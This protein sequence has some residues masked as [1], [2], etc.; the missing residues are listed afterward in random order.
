MTGCSHAYRGRRPENPPPRG[1]RSVAANRTRTPG[2]RAAE[3]SA[4]HRRPRRNA[5][6]DRRPQR[7]PPEARSRRQRAGW[8]WSWGPPLALGHLGAR[9][10][11]S[12][13]IGNKCQQTAATQ[14]PS[15]VRGTSRTLLRMLR[16]EG[17]LEFRRGRGISVAGTPERSAVVQRAKELVE[18]ARGQGYR[19]DELHLTSR[20]TSQNRSRLFSAL[21]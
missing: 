19:L 16:D 13:W 11:L 15:A 17:L 8:W 2:S 10:R 1:A 5:S 9:L 7:N 12:V 14:S 3:R 20:V 18:F 6:S 21:R 4:A